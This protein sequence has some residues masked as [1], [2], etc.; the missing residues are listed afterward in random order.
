MAFSILLNKHRQ[1]ASAMCPSLNGKR[2]TVHRLRHTMAMDLL[3]ADVDGGC[4]H[5]EM[6]S[7]PKRVLV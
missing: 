6:T 7:G 2:V 3:Q 1:T 4:A 5:P